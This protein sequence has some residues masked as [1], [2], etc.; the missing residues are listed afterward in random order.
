MLRVARPSM[1]VPSARYFDLC[2]GHWKRLLPPSYRSAVFWCGHA[3][4]NA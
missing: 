3:S 4:E 1:N 2:F